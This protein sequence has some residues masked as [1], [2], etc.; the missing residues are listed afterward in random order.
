MVNLYGNAVVHQIT[1]NDCDPLIRPDAV[2][3][4]IEE[5]RQVVLI[6]TGDITIRIVN[7]EGDGLLEGKASYRT[8]VA[9]RGQGEGAPCKLERAGVGGRG[10]DASGAGHHPHRAAGR[11]RHRA[12]AP[13][14][15]E[16][17]PGAGTGGQ[18]AP[19]LPPGLPG[20]PVPGQ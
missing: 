10:R 17:D 20:L 3:H 13:R 2:R 6:Q 8:V 4:V 9:I 12:R 14:D 5:E 16:A 11:H 19:Q 7:D 1:R 15:P 18:R